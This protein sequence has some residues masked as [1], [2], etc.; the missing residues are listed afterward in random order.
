MFFWKFYNPNN[1]PFSFPAV[2]SLFDAAT[3]SAQGLCASVVC[4]LQL[5][6]QFL[7]VLQIV[8]ILSKDIFLAAVY[9]LVDVLFKQPLSF[10]VRD[11]IQKDKWLR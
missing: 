5:F 8:L 1:A 3:E 6:D 11:Y 9:F 4:K 7:S 2:P 10:Y